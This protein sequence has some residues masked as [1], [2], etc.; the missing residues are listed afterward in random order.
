MTAWS[1]GYANP[2]MLSL[3][4]FVEKRY[5]APTTEKEDW[6]PFAEAGRVDSYAA[7]EF[8]IENRHAEVFASL[9]LSKDQREKVVLAVALPELLCNVWADSLYGG[10]E[11][12]S[13]NFASDPITERWGEIWQANGGDDVLGWESIFGTAFRGTGVWK[14]RRAFDDEGRDEAIVIEEITPAIYFPRLKPD[15]RTLDYVVIA[16]EE[17]VNGPD[18]PRAEIWQRREVHRMDGDQYVID[19]STRRASSSSRLEWRQWKPSERPDNVDF[20]P[21]VDMHTKRWAGRYWGMSELQRN[22]SIFDEI[23]DRLSAIG[24]ILDYHGSPILQVP[25]SVL[26]GGVFFKG[27]DRTLGVANADEAQLA[28]YITYDGQASNQFAAIDK[29]IELAFL[30]AEVPPAYF[31]MMEGAAYSGSA[32]RLR[33]Q[34]YLKKAARY[35][36]KDEARIRALA[37]MA[38]RLDGQNDDEAIVPEMIDHGDPLPADDNENAQI[39][40]LLFS[41]KLSSRET[42]IRRLRRVKDVTQEI[43]RIEKEQAATGELAQRPLTPPAGLAAAGIQPAPGTNPPSR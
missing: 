14:L 6:P 20:L 8:L 22:L 23:D 2:V 18:D 21:F 26:V 17:D 15:G 31:G 40:N 25:K 19:Y 3:T 12:P 13:V 42:S 27:A 28:R 30:T 10:D 5:V 35:M 16:F 7:Y 11:P 39:E 29:A 41:G 36:R 33:L 43:G 24:E 4:P 37:R 32:L 34:N 1:G 38:L 9:Q